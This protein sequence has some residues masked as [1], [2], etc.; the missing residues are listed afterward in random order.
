MFLISAPPSFGKDIKDQDV[1][2][3]DQLKVKIPFSGTG[4]FDFKLKHNGRNVPNNDRLKMTTFDDYVV[5]QLKDSELDD[6][7]KY[8]I[9]VKNESGTCAASFGVKVKGKDYVTCWT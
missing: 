8:T 6:S 4:P 2:L 1:E 9:E 5:V 7:G 3:G